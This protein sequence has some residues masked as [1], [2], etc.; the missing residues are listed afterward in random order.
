MLFR[1][2]CHVGYVPKIQN[3]D[4]E[5]KLGHVTKKSGMMYVN[6]RSIFCEVGAFV[7]DVILHD[8]G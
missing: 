6:D 4:S 1:S 5:Q 8:V 7:D 2:W 3:L